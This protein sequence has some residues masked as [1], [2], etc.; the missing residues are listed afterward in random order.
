MISLSLFDNKHY[1]P[2]C[3]DY[4]RLSYVFVINQLSVVVRLFGFARFSNNI[5][6]VLTTNTYLYRFYE[7]GCVLA[8]NNHKAIV[9][10]YSF[11]RVC[12]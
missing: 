6:V 11:A 12:Q 10:T 2:T 5:L 8:I 7:I 3:C 9:D 1:C 4:L